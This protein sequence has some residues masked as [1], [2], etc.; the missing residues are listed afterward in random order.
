MILL[1]QN[2]LRYWKTRHCRHKNLLWAENNSCKWHYKIN[3]A[4]PSS[5]KCK[6]SSNKFSESINPNPFHL[7]TR[8]RVLFTE[9]TLSSNFFCALP[10]NDEMKISFMFKLFLSNSLIIRFSAK[11][12]GIIG[13]CVARYN[14]LCVVFFIWWCNRSLSKYLFI[15]GWSSCILCSWIAYPWVDGMGI[16][17]FCCGLAKALV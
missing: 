7:R 17:F 16:V 8:F 4:L 3:I 1:L 10:I 13:I 14:G 15:E 5:F 12:P 9:I 6:L 2:Y 11:S